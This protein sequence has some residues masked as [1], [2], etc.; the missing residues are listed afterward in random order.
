MRWSFSIG[1]YAGIPVRVHAT[2]FLIILWALMTGMRSGGSA[3]ALWGVLFTLALFACV[4][5]HEFGHSLAARRYGIATRDIT[6]LP[7]G[8]V[9]RLER[10]PTEPRQELVVAL[11]GPIV[12]LAIAAVLFAVLAATGRFRPEL[13]MSGFPGENF[14]E[15]LVF[16]NVILVLF[17]ILPAFPMDGGRVL[18]ALLATRLPYAR[19]TQVAAT[20]GQGMALLF[21]LLGLFGNPFLLFIAFFVWIGATQESGMVQVRTALSG[22]PVRSAMLTEFRVLY[23]GE[24][25]Q[26]AVEMILAG[27]QQDFPVLEGT[28]VVGILTRAGLIGGL[29]KLGPEAP[30]GAVMIRDFPTAE[31]SEML[32]NVLGRLQE[33]VVHVVPV[34]D[35]GRLVGLVTNDNVSEFLAI[36]AAVGR[37]PRTVA[38]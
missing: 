34:V 12:S 37:I 35:G 21:G 30:V 25:L 27:S 18:R 20:L 31:S 10:M 15:Q 38:A 24:P 4:V 3:G 19:A 11:A 16:I 8:G 29:S 2:F 5:L 17:N 26:R 28:Q 7:I 32:E 33:S 1:T 22:I 14:I 13:A 6:L 23:P 36:Q 9:S